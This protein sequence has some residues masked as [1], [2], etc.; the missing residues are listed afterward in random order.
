MMESIFIS[1][2][3]GDDEI[4]AIYATAKLNDNP[5]SDV[6]TATEVLPIHVYGI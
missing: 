3:A 6:K 4:A 5:D 1:V 2:H